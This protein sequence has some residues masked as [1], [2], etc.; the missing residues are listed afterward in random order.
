MGRNK[1][2]ASFSVYCY[3]QIPRY[4]SESVKGRKKPQESPVDCIIRPFNGILAAELITTYLQHIVLS[5]NSL[6]QT[7][8]NVIICT[9]FSWESPSGNEAVTLLIWHINNCLRLNS[10]RKT[11]V[12]EESW[13]CY[14]FKESTFTKFYKLLPLLAVFATCE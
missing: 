10:R 6:S 7:A 12:L 8:R 9:S 4:A 1:N 2:S 14:G 3:F 5:R 13:V 11:W